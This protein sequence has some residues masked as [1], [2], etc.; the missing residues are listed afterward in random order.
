MALG[1]QRYHDISPVT[2]Q[3]GGQRYHDISP[4]TLQVGGQVSSSLY[5]GEV[6]GPWG[7]QVEAFLVELFRC[8]LCEFTCSRRGPIS[9]HLLSH[10]A[11]GS[12]YQD[13][14]GGAKQDEDDFLLYN[15]L[16]SPAPPG[17]PPPGDISGEVAHTCEVR[18]R[19]EDSAQS[20]HLM[21][22]GLC[23]I[24]K[25]APPLTPPLWWTPNPQVRPP[26][27]PAVLQQQGGGAQ[28]AEK[29]KKKRRRS[30][31]SAEAQKTP[32]GWSQLIGRSEGKEAGPNDRSFSSPLTL[33]RHLGSHGGEKPFSCPHCSYCSRLKASLLQHLR[34]HTGEKPF[35]C[36][37]CSY[38]SID[39]SSLLR[40]CRT[41]SQEKPYSC[42][43]C[44]YSSIQKKSL[45]LHAR[46]HHSGEAFPCRQCS[47]SSPDQQL[48]QRHTRR[49]H[50]NT[51]DPAL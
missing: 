2:L 27:L 46:R 25:T 28:T 40:H 1:G 42:T 20:A 9:T 44:D 17:S 13:L 31:D 45:D 19:F 30:A 50:G 36:A 24:S 32:D 33:R 8:K 41:H 4:V 11:G 43:H 18:S 16:I 35:R 23:R 47:Y 22:L 49:H 7:G 26:H 29:K 51:E 37:E 34:T 10:R 39:R 38:A 21:T 5:C 48:L 15:I 3:V 12:P 6:G 14:S